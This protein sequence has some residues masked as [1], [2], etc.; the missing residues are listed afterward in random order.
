MPPD[1]VTVRRGVFGCGG[2]TATYG[3][4]AEAV[5]LDREEPPPPGAFPHPPPPEPVVVGVSVPRLD[6]PDKVVGRPRFVHDLCL[7]GRLYGRVLRPPSP[8]ARLVR[9]RPLEGVRVV[10]D[11]SFLG[12]L[13]ETEPEA[14]R[15]LARLR[16]AAEWEERDTL[17]DERDLHAYLRTG[18]HETIAVLTTTDNP[19][20]EPDTGGSPTTGE[21]P[22][23]TVHTA[24]YSRPFI[25]HASIAP[26]CAVARWNE[27]DGTLEV[28]SHT[29]GVHP[30]RTAL[31]QVLGHPADRIEVRHVEGA[32]CYGHN[33]ADDVALDAALLARAAPGRPVQVRWSRQDEL[34]WAPFG[35]AMSADVTAAVDA[36]G[37][38]CSWAYDVW[39]Q[40]HVSRPGH[41]GFPGLLAGA[42]LEQPLTYPAAGEP[43]PA[44]GGGMARNAVPIYDFPHLRITGHRLLETPIRTSALRSLGA[45]MNVFAI[46]SFMDE[47]ALAADLDPLAYR[48]AHLS[49]ERGREVLRRAADAAGWRGPGQ[50]LGFARYKGNG[51]YC[52]AVA[53]VEAE[54]HVRVRHLTIAVDV[55]QV[56]NPDGVRNQIE[57]G[58][59]Q[60]A[61]WTLKERVRFDRRRITSGDWASYPILRFSEAPE[62]SVELVEHPG[63]PS[64]GAGEAAQGPV[65]AAIANAVAYALGVRVRD[66]PLTREAVLAAIER[67]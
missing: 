40:G 45:F 32:G 14:D 7:P 17:P 25:A 59:T 5:P 1:A 6:L 50:G 41:R 13:G 2:L 24:T 43:S 58:A 61:S 63:T 42:H 28:W 21:P 12:V 48:L 38:V 57:G 52:A 23:G 65:A 19:P 66:L 37:M 22:A 3:D 55:G 10:R 26:S 31:A 35:S 67:D 53:E 47:L 51:A 30:L 20:A 46:E 56:V 4:L 39:S 33:G 8:G 9:L 11:G 27:R 34:T 18:P 49:D 36:T 62:V 15:A 64:V 44:S 54:H 29:Q 60:A 16:K